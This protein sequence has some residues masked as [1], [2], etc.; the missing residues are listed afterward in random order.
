[1]GGDAVAVRLKPDGK[2]L[3]AAVC[4]DLAFMF[5]PAAGQRGGGNG[6]CGDLHGIV[7]SRAAEIQRSGYGG[8]TAARFG[9]LQNNAVVLRQGLYGIPTDGVL[10]LLYERVGNMR[11]ENIA[12]CLGIRNKCAV[13][14]CLHAVALRPV[15]IAGCGGVGLQGYG[16]V[17][18][19]VF[20][21][22]RLPVGIKNILSER[23]AVDVVG[24]GAG[25]QHGIAVRADTAVCADNVIGL[26]IAQN[27]GIIVI[28]Q[29]LAYGNIPAGAQSRRAGHQPADTGAGNFHRV[30]V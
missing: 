13:A 24:L 19:G 28:A 15:Y 27:N 25:K 17:A 16:I 7:I 20:Y 6:R 29:R 1:M 26:G 23:D 30:V 8:G 11:T 9:V 2:F 21:F 22:L 14:R 10:I 12:L 3:L 5:G 18:G 4:Q